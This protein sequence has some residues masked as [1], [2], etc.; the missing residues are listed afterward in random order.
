M[1]PCRRFMVLRPTKGVS[2]NEESAQRTHIDV[3]LASAHRV[4]DSNGVHR[5]LYI[6]NP[7]NVRAFHDG[8]NGAGN[9]SAEPVFNRRVIEQL[10]DKRLSRSSDHDRQVRESSRDLI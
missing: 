2:K 7:H 9:S 1:Y 10:S 3:R 8:S 5:L 4:K 6:M